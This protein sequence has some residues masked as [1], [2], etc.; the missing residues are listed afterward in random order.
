MKGP[1]K[2][3]GTSRRRSQRKDRHSKIFT[4]KGPRDRRMR[5][6]LDVARK[7][8]DLQDMLGFDKASKTVD[9]LLNNA[10]MSIKD[11]ASCSSNA[12]PVAGK[13]ESSISECEVISSAVEN[14]T[15]PSTKGFPKGPSHLGLSK[16]SRVL[17]R[18]RARERTREKMGRRKLSTEMLDGSCSGRSSPELICGEDPVPSQEVSTLIVPR[19]TSFEINGSI[20]NQTMGF[21][22]EQWSM[23]S[24]SNAEEQRVIVPDANQIMAWFWDPFCNPSI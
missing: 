15:F 1:L 10:K 4:A 23:H 14:S 12:N 20:I 24:S 16:E 3:V 18:A 5:L 9:W 22:Q 21:L 6:S 11:L 8:F 2:A 17:A 13:S 19:S 7:F